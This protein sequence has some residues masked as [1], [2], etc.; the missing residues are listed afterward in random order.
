MIGKFVMDEAGIF[1]FGGPAHPIALRPMKSTRTLFAALVAACFITVAA[2]AAD[3][4]SPTGTW[5]WMQPGFNGG[6]ASERKV[7]LDYKDGKLTGKALGFE[8]GQGQIPDAPISEASFKDGAIAFS[9]VRD[10]G[11]TPFTVK[12]SGKLDGDTIKGQIDRPGFNG[13]EATK[14][15]W[16]ASR[17][18]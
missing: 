15:E 17:A 8:G 16:V 10:F 9:V 13:G 14:I 3:A 7:Q 4:A 2:F 1:L 5:K 6:E 11:G 18:K 12:Y